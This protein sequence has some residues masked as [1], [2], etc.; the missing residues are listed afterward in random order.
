MKEI[1]QGI[2]D[3]ETKLIH[4]DDGSTDFLGETTIAKILDRGRK[5]K[6]WNTKKLIIDG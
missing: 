1:I 2:V 5:R 6:R 3:P 4:H